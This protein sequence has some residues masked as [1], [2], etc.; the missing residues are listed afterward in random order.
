MGLL[1]VSIWLPIIFGALI[2]AVGS[3]QKAGMV[4][5]LALLASLVSLAV[6]LPLIS[7]FDITTAQMQFVEKAPWIERF[8][9]YYHLGVCLL[10]TSPSPRDR[11]RSRM[12]SSA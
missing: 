6:T 4:R 5:T 12:P 7:G 3:D 9:V 8:N 1:S 2:L 10:Y 11:T